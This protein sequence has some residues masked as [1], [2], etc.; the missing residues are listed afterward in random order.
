MNHMTA[1]P[2]PDKMETRTC[3]DCGGEGSFETYDCWTCG[4]TGEITLEEYLERIDDYDDDE[5]LF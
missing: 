2:Y 5:D 3:P 4:G 1:I